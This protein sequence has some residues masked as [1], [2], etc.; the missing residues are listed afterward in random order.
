M[1]STTT[2]ENKR[3]IKKKRKFDQPA[4][5]FFHTTSIVLIRAVFLSTVY[6]VANKLKL[7]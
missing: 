2:K 6:K 4:L 5:Q 7:E 3:K 1:L